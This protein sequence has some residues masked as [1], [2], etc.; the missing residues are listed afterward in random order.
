MARLRG[1]AQRRARPRDRRLDPRDRRRRARHREPS[2]RRSSA[3]LADPGDADLCALPLR[4]RFLGAWLGPAAK[5]PNYRLR[6][7][8][9]GAYRHDEA[10]LVHEGL[11]SRGPVRPLDGELEHL[12]ADGWSEALRDTW[13]YARLDAA[14]APAL[15]GAVAYARALVARPAAKFAYRLVVDGGWRD[16]LAGLVRIGLDCLSDV[17]VIGRRLLGRAGRA[18]R[19]RA[20]RSGSLRPRRQSV[21]AGAARRR[22]HRRARSE[23]GPWPGSRPRARPAPTSR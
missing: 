11:V 19:R 23:R 1:A 2:S 13:L 15:G 12:L 5:Y 17:L 21:R 22:R 20:R 8:R 3:F 4:E 14:Q 6:L 10:R 7:F 18:A 9:R 16:G